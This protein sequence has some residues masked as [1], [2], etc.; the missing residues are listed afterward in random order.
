MSISKSLVD[1]MCK[2]T[3]QSSS[4]SPI[5][6]CVSQTYYWA[7]LQQLLQA[8]LTWSCKR[9]RPSHDLLHHDWYPVKR[10]IKI[11]DSK[12]LCIINEGYILTIKQPCQKVCEQ[13]GYLGLC[14]FKTPGRYS[15]WSDQDSALPLIMQLCK[16]RSLSTWADR[17]STQTTFT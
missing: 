7:D 2:F 13:V 1:D 16:T 11:L 15:R 12:S 8:A 10:I 5:W 6:W 14:S 3:F 9:D 4:H 17:F